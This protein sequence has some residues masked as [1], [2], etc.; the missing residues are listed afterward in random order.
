MNAYVIRT[1]FLIPNACNHLIE[2]LSKPLPRLYSM[3]VGAFSLAVHCMDYQNSS[4]RP[5]HPPPPITT[6][7]LDN[8]LLMYTQKSV[9]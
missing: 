5:R 3:G 8:S 1:E 4:V 9:K 6:S 7:V 2:D